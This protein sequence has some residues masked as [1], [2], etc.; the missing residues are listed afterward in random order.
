MILIT[1]LLDGLQTKCKSNCKLEN[2]HSTLHTTAKV[3]KARGG[4]T[5]APMSHFRRLLPDS[6]SVQRLH[7][8]IAVPWPGFPSCNTANN[9]RNCTLLLL[10]IVVEARVKKFTITV[11]RRLWALL[12][13]GYAWTPPIRSS[14]VGVCVKQPRILDIFGGN[15]QKLHVLSNFTVGPGQDR[16]SKVN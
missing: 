9:R 1:P 6:C 15:C 16:V 5:K 4:A 10:G 11:R 14:C 8:L 7:A 12:L 3:V 13:G 2:F